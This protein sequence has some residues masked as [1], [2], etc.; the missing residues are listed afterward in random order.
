M[1]ALSFDELRARALGVIEAVE[2]ELPG[3]VVLVVL[4]SP[5]GDGDNIRLAAETNAGQA[6]GAEILSIISQAWG[7]S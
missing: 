5:T 7:R 4:G 2:A 1:A 3:L 6:G